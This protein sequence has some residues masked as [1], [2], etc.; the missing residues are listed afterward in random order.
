MGV[1]AGKSGQEFN[2]IVLEKIKKLR[3]MGFEAD[4]QMDGGMTAE[5]IQMCYKAGANQ[6]S[7]TSHLWKAE[8]IDRELKWLAGVT[9]EVLE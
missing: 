3:E 6:F 8:D 5:T 7:V 4:I 2:P 1:K 9:G